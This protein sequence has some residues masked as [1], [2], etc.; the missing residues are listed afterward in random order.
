MKE[1]LTAMVPLKFYNRLK[2][3]KDEYDVE[4]KSMKGVAEGFVEVTVIGE[5]SNLE[6]LNDRVSM[7]VYG[8]VIKRR[9]RK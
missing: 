3:L 4:L 1:E 9:K 5:M 8:H 7:S 2:E 6:A